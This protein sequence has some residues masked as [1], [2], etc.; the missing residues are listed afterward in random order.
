LIDFDTHILS[1]GLRISAHRDKTSQL[2]SV[3]L[4]YKAGSKYDPQDS[5]GT[6]HL[7][8]HLMFSGSENAPDFDEPQQ[9]AGGENNAYTNA[10]IAHYYQV[11]PTAHIDIALWLE[12]DR[13]FSLKLNENKLRTQKKVISEEFK[14]T[15]T[16]QPFGDVWHHM[17]PM[18]YARHPYR[19]PTMGK[20]ID[21]IASVT[22][23]E[24]FEFYTRHYRPERAVLA[25]AGPE[26]TQAMIEKACRWFDRP[27]LPADIDPDWYILPTD[28]PQTSM[29][30]KEVVNNK[31]LRGVF[32]GFPMPGRLDSGYYECDLLSDLLGNGNS[33]VL[34]RELV[35][36]AQIFSEIDAYIN[37][38]VDTG[39]LI[40]E[41]RPADGVPIDNALNAIWEQLDRIRS[42]EVGRK[43]LMK[44]KN[45][46]ETTL[47]FSEMG[48][49]SKAAN[50]A[51]F[52]YLGD[53]NRI[54]HELDYYN[55]ISTEDIK[56]WANRIL[57]PEN[58]NVV[59]YR[60][61]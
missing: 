61:I 10:D 58:A 55:S 20:N 2:A 29:R 8:E 39:L 6:A 60:P 37:G 15:V 59:V 30:F 9:L 24:A 32:I 47:I 46:V 23:K 44:W 35:E 28:A 48:I 5:T 16:N 3:H 36:E 41:G 49:Q 21:D 56:D 14:E 31:D 50:M 26:E 43:E 51:Y 40:I 11:I 18:I 57:K 17:Y 13:M 52:D 1:N 45:K 27:N 4:I 12:A 42:S 19:W 22:L 38:N 33:S 54:N 34:I 53:L 25:I 7:F